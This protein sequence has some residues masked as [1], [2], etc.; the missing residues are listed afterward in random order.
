M[1]L[2]I[3]FTIFHNVFYHVLE[4]Q[5]FGPLCIRCLQWFW[6][7]M[8]IIAASDL[9]RIKYW[10][11]ELQESMDRCTGRQGMT[12]ILLKTAFN[13]IQSICRCLQMF[14]ILMIRKFVILAWVNPFPNKPWFLLVCGT[15]LLKTLWEKGGLKKTLGFFFCFHELMI[16]VVI[17]FENPYSHCWPLFQRWLRHIVWR[18]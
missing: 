5:F 11:K 7:L 4:L 17:G 1:L 8:I 13:T 10:L 15:S 3:T 12:E 6:G 9:E 18:S 14:K 2:N 16:V